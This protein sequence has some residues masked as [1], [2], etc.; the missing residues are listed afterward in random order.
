MILTTERQLEAD[1][2]QRAATLF[3]AF[4]NVVEAYIRS[5][6]LTVAEGQSLIV[7]AQIAIDQLANEPAPR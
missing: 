2:A 3:Q 6:A 5:D 4:I 1:N 7:A